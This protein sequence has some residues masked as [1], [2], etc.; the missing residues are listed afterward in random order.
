MVLT[1]GIGLDA[2]EAVPSRQRLH[3]P[4]RWCRALRQLLGTCIESLNAMVEDALRLQATDLVAANS[5]W[6][7]I[8]HQVVEEAILGPMSNPLSTYAICARVC[9]VQ[10]H[11]RW[12]ILRS[13]PLV[14]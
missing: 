13:R 9:N 11:P 3:Q 4:Q 10:V 7:K 5:A 12:G 2:G 1:V 14:Q 8:E 6:T